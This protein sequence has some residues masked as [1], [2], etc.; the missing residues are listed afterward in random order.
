MAIPAI[1]GETDASITAAV[2]GP[3]TGCLTGRT[4]GRAGSLTLADA[5]VAVE[6]ALPGNASARA[7]V[8]LALHDLAASCLGVDLGQL[9]DGGPSDE[10]ASDLT[11]SVDQP[12]AVAQAAVRALAEG[13]GTVKLKLADPEFDVARVR[14]VRDALARAPGGADVVLRVDANQA[15][16]LE[17]AVRVLDRIAALGISLELVEQPVA[18][19]DLA[20]MA[21]V[22]ERSPYPVVADESAFTA[23]D[24]DRVAD[25]GA[26]DA[27][28]VKL[29]K[30]GG[31][32]PARAVIAACAQTG[33]GVL[34]G[35]MLEPAEGV[36][37][38]RALAAAATVG[39]SAHDLD[40]GWWVAG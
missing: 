34:V 39:D 10:V 21:W 18:A 26:A 5:V 3:L 14:A 27:V 9:L 30:C 24:V 29:L 37:A 2:R 38:A 8:D 19:A 16:A 40:A 22:R 32:G 28:V 25:A 15:W 12:A 23:A 17:Q 33:L 35:C 20:G 1:T 31:L 6:Q 7:G 36:A 4:D 13:F 11:V